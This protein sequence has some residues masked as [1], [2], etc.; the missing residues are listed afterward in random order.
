MQKVQLVPKRYRV[1]IEGKSGPLVIA[2]EVSQV[3]MVSELDNYSSWF[4][5]FKRD[6]DIVASFPAGQGI[7]GYHIADQKEL[8]KD[9]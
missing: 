5:V 2:D 8:Q 6:G 1:L 9:A 3:E 4:T 7:T